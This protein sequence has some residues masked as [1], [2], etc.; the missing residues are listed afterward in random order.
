MNKVDLSKLRESFS[1]DELYSFYD[2]DGSLSI[3]KIYMGLNKTGKMPCFYKTK[4]YASMEQAEKFLREEAG[5]EVLYSMM[6]TGMRN[7]ED[8]SSEAWQNRAFTI[9]DG[10]D[11]FFIVLLKK[12]R[13]LET[14]EVEIH[15]S[16]L[17]DSVFS[18]KFKNWMKGATKPKHKSKVGFIS[19]MGSYWDM[20]E[21]DIKDIPD[22]DFDL[23][24][25]SDFDHNKVTNLVNTSVAGLIL[26]GGLPGTGKTNYLRWLMGHSTKK[27]VYMPSSQ[28][29][30]MSSPSF[31][32][33]A[34]SNLKDCVL[35]ME[36]C[37]DVLIA[38]NE[39]KHTEVQTI[40]NLSDGILGSALNLTIIG[41]YNTKDNIDKA[42]FR[43]GR[44]L[45]MYDFGS[46]SADKAERLSEHLGH[47]RKYGA[48]VT[49]S[50]I[51]NPEDNMVKKETKSIGFATGK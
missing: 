9:N 49:L 25:N 6:S 36:D 28:V 13:N 18:D 42:L 2:S 8:D 47:N 24:Y 37:E 40:L 26:L 41:T 5:A 34:L 27:F 51:Y 12:E 29:H 22:I 16:E 3:S 1:L 20:E 48:P 46:L 44:L 17:E 35:L 30:L 10:E 32:S 15:Y 31:I 50:E 23:N 43:K 19:Q 4:T 33:F 7:I 14:I 39:M 11:A 45:Y 21:V 38:R